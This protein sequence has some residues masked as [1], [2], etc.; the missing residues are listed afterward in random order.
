MSTTAG[1]VRILGK[2]VEWVDSAHEDIQSRHQRWRFL[3]NEFSFDTYSVLNF[4]AGTAAI[5]AGDTVT[6]EDS[7]ATG[8]AAY[9]ATVNSGTYG[10]NDAAGY[11]A[12]TGVTGTFED[13]ENLQVSAGTK[14]VANGTAAFTAT[15]TPT[16]VGLTEHATWKKDSFRLYLTSQSDEQWLDYWEWDLFRDAHLLGSEATTP[17]RPIDFSIKA[18][19][20]LHLWP[21]PDNNYTVVGEYWKRP[22]T[23]SAD[24]SEPLFPDEFHMAVVYRALMFY[25]GYQ[26]ALTQYQRAEKEFKRLMFS[27]ENN[28]LEMFGPI[29]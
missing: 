7:G 1:Q 22:D 5:S 15:Y 20:T 24:T 23:F 13:D 3:K 12:L 10:T 8:T 28:Q 18:D 11:L 29:R 2:I 4:D 17:G 16:S 26:E 6:G 25:A 9:D 21:V 19:R 14:S 27:L